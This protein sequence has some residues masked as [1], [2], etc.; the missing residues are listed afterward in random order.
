M[1]AEQAPA[2]RPGGRT[3]RVTERLYAAAVE[4]LAER[5]LDGLQYDEL[6]TRAGVARATVYRRWPDRDGLLADVL[7]HFA[8]TSVP[9][10]DTGDVVED[11]VAFV[12]AFAEAAASPAGRVVLQVLLRRPDEG[13]DLRRAGV[14][15][16]DQ[17]TGDL[18]KRLDQAA[19]AG[20]LPPVAAPFVNMMLT[21]PV[22]WF[23]LRRAGALSA[24]EAREIVDLVVAGLRHPGRP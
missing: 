3:R 7:A 23:T 9:I 13:D 14:R 8:Q 19:S 10:P 21:G 22:Q 16:L 12:H 20:Q 18:Q 4:L 15:L 1:P 2:R 17:R 6:A 11:L 24:A 5:G